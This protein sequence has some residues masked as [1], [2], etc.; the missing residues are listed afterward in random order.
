MTNRYI[1]LDLDNTLIYA[2]PVLE[3]DRLKSNE[4]AFAVQPNGSIYKVKIRDHFGHFIDYLLTN[5]YKLIVWSAGSEHYVKSITERIFKRE[6]IV[7]LLTYNDLTD[8]KIK[9][10]DDLRQHIKDIDM[11]HVRL[12]DDNTIHKP[13]QEKH[14]IHIKPFKGGADD[15]LLNAMDDIDKSFH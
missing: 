6:Q 2:R 4:F 10:L 12:L 13:G 11:E 5:G 8:G 3:V 14:F 7:H 1:V 15:G 9:I